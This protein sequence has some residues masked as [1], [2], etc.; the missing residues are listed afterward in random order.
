[1]SSTNR[2]LSPPLTYCARGIVFDECL[3]NPPGI[4][5]T[6]IVALSVSVS[7]H[8]PVL[9]TSL[10]NRMFCCEMFS[11]LIFPRDTR[12]CAHTTHLQIYTRAYRP[13]SVG[14]Y[15]NDVPFLGLKLK[16]N[17]RTR[18]LRGFRHDVRQYRYNK[19]P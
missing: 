17:T 12:A 10:S 8:S 9:D 18:Y 15:R 1:M 19:G 11:K 14:A 6:F 2:A 13:K 4:I 16:K 7:R 5:D 3:R